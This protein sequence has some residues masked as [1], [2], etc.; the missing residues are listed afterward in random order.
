MSNGHES[1]HEISIERLKHWLIEHNEQVSREYSSPDAAFLRRQ[2]RANHK[3]EIVA[4]ECM[5]GRLNLA[6]MSETPLGIVQSVRN[7]GGIFDLG[8]FYLNEMFDDL[9]GYAV[10]HGRDCLA[11]VTY[12]WSRGELHRGC[13]G[14][15]YNVDVARTDMMHMTHQI[16]EIFGV[17]HSVVYPICLG[18]ET[19]EDAFLFHGSEGRTLDVSTLRDPSSDELRI[20]LM[21]LYPDMK[22]QMLNDLLPI[23]EGNVRHVAAVRASNRQIL[24]AEHRERILGVGRGFDWLHVNNLA[25]IVGPFDPNLDGAIEVATKLLLGNIDA[26]RIPQDGIILLASETYRDPAGSDKPGAM[27]KSRF[28][29]DFALK[30]IGKD[31]PSLRKLLIPMACVVDVNT[32]KLHLI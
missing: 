9:V 25:L 16:E 26:K 30:T 5:D 4:F 3:T 12:H 17:K 23:V 31:V 14:H 32:R 24:D 21:E 8:W 15:N 22:K 20:R 2:Y 1:V 7:L 13:R 27:V 11:F 18:I 29:R 10:K 28:A 6:L 19:D